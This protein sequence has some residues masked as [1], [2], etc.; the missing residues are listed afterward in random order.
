MKINT[1]Y[2][3]L[4]TL[5]F[6]LLFACEKEKHTEDEHSIEEE[7]H[8]NEDHPITFT[9]MQLKNADIELGTLQ[10][11][12]LS[13]LVNVTGRLAVPPQAKANISPIVGGN[14]QQIFVEEGD[15]VRKGEVLAT[16]IQP[17]LTNIQSDYLRAYQEMNFLQKENTR[18]ENL[19]KAGVASG[20]SYE[21]VQSNYKATQALVK[22]YESQLKQ[23][24]L[25]PAAIRKGNFYKGISL[26][27]PINGYVEEVTVKLGEYVTP[28]MSLFNVMDN[29]KVHADIM[30]YEKDIHKIKKGQ[31]I[32]LHLTSAPEEVFTATIASIGQQFEEAS[33]AVHIHAELND[34]K[35]F[36]LPNMSLNGEILTD[37]NQ[38]LALPEDAIIYDEDKPYI[39]SA[40]EDNTHTPSIWEMKKIEINTGIKSDGWVEIK[41]LSPLSPD[42]LIVQKNAYYIMAEMKKGETSHEH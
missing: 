10:K 27:S 30:V 2:I 36:L 5:T 6:I 23:M 20:K 19:Y 12:A 14:I 17:D 29:S 11:R 22:G 33:K 8:H 3:R 26:Y 4:F 32:R 15:R 25:S 28:Q 38:V 7:H 39:F 35:D 21:Q 41:L 18:K 13:G 37:N 1:S 16:I 31:Q 34:K 42:A 9:D 24:G 40:K